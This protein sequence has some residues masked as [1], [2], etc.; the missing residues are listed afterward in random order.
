[1]KKILIVDN[2]FDPP[3]GCP[4]IRHHLEACAKKFGAIEVTSVR[5]PEGEVASVIPDHYDG[6]V[7][8]GSKTRLAEK[9]PWIDLEMALIG[10][11]YKK[12]K[13]TLG[14]CYGEQLMARVLLGIDCAGAAEKSE[15]GWGEIEVNGDS[16]ILK[17]L[18]KK[19][20]S[21]QAHSDE[22]YQVK[23]PLALKA[24]SRDCRVQAYDVEDAPMWGLQFHPER[25]LAEG[26]RVIDKKLQTDPNFRPLNRAIAETAYSEKTAEIIFTNFLSIVWAR[27]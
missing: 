3:H 10:M 8:S 19:F 27:K 17:G 2:T 1:M 15:Y 26:N 24:S 13:P 12:K 22:V 7:L 21:Y 25:G 18:P 23:S 4:E 6:F 14:I 9:A 11:L 16:P 5:A 20:Y